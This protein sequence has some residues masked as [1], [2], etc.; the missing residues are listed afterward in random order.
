MLNRI[1]NLRDLFLQQG[2][3]LYSSTLQEL[4]ELPKIEKQVSSPVLKKLI[5]KKIMR[6]QNE[7]V[8]LAE[9]LKEINASPDGNGAYATESILKMMQSQINRCTDSAARDAGVIL[10]LQRLIHWKLAGLGTTSAFA[11][12]IGQE[13]GAGT[14]LDVLQEAKEL[15]RELSQLA[16]GEINRQANASVGLYSM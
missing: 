6:I 2:R 3:E 4:A 11:A 15:D 8:K 7:Q 12:E 1:D 10:N 16:R 13:K 14:L 9:V 5:N